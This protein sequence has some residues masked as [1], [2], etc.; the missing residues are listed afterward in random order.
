MKNSKTLKHENLIMKKNL[1]MF[2]LISTTTFLYSMENDSDAVKIYSFLHKKKPNEQKDKEA[3]FF[4][5]YDF[6]C[7][8]KIQEKIEGYRPKY[9]IQKNFNSIQIYKQQHILAAFKRYSDHNYRIKTIFSC[10]HLDFF[11]NCDTDPIMNCKCNNENCN[12]G[13]THYSIKSNT[14]THLINTN[15]YPSFYT[16][17]IDNAHSSSIILDSHSAV[18]NI[19]KPFFHIDKTK[20]KELF[21]N[22]NGT[23]VVVVKNKKNVRNNIIIAQ[24][25]KASD[26]GFDTIFLIKNKLLKLTLPN[27]MDLG[28]STTGNF[29]LI[30][31]IFKNKNKK[32][33]YL[34]L[35]SISDNKRLNFFK[36]KV[37]SSFKDIQSLNNN[38]TDW[39]AI[40][41]K[42]N[43][44]FITITPNNK[45]KTYNQTLTD[46]DSTYFIHKV[47]VNTKCNKE[48]ALLITKKSKHENN[49]Y[50]LGVYHICIDNRFNNKKDNYVFRNIAKN[51]E[52]KVKNIN[53]FNFDNNN[54]IVGIANENIDCSHL[55][56]VRL[57]KTGDKIIN[58]V[59]APVY[60]LSPHLSITKKFEN[61]NIFEFMRIS[62]ISSWKKIETEYKKTT[63]T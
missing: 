13:I 10:N 4:K 48:L 7:S 39:V 63:N 23:V 62:T 20:S 53:I 41:N 58:T 46:S 8:H 1:L 51:L 28:I 54:V 36:Q 33:K 18:A 17:L 44:C 25:N 42:N 50:N 16:E 55:K 22:G 45:I 27:I 31:S 38:G 43:L 15:A 32:L 14:T 29:I 11:T 21:N 5:N 57:Q 56:T 52:F 37:K 24:E 19:K 60:S 61:L 26:S 35:I 47:T 12:Q 59:T 3:E 34:S 30:F 49:D 2:F 9:P 40:D 6:N